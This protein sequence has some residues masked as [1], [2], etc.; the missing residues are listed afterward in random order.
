MNCRIKRWDGEYRWHTVR[1]VPT[2]PGPQGSNEWHATA[3]DVHELRLAEQRLNETQALAKIGSW[4]FDPIRMTR[5]WTDAVYSMFEMDQSEEPF[6]FEGFLKLVHPHDRERIS[7]EMPA[8]MAT[9]GEFVLE[10][11]VVLPSG[12]EKVIRTVARTEVEEGRVTRILGTGQDVTEERTADADRLRLAAVVE[13]SSDLVATCDADGKTLFMNRALRT[14]VGL[15]MDDCIRGLPVSTFLT[16][17]LFQKLLKDWIP[18]SIMHGSWS[19]EAEYESNGRRLATSLM[20]IAHANADGRSMYFSLVARDI[21]SIKKSERALEHTNGLLQEAARHFERLFHGLPIACFSYGVD[22]LVREWNPAAE[23]MFG[24]GASDAYEQPI[25]DV[26]RGSCRRKSFRTLLNPVFQGEDMEGVELNIVRKDGSTCIAV[27][28]TMPVRDRSGVVIAALSAFVDV[29]EQRRATKKLKANEQ[30]LQSIAAS[31]HEG[32]IVEDA[33]GAIILTNSSAER[34]LGVSSTKLLALRSTDQLWKA[35]GEDGT[36]LSPEE[37]PSRIARLS[38]KPTFGRKMGIK[39][40]ANGLVW[41]N[42]NAIPI[43]SKAEDDGLVV[44]SFSD[45]SAEVENLSTIREYSERLEEANQ[46]LERLATTDGLTG[47]R[48]HRTFQEYLEREF[49]SSVRYERPLSIALLDVDRFKLINDDF[50]H[51]VGDE[52]LKQIAR[53]LETAARDADFVARYGGEEFVVVMPETGRDAALVAAERFRAIIEA[54]EW[55]GRPVTASFGV[56]TLTPL[57]RHRAALI[58]Q[59]DQALYAAKRAGRNRSVHYDSLPVVD[60]TQAA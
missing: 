39:K 9:E 30:R 53:I 10:Y 23:R 55:K 26:V 15:G 54:A 37:V 19:G 18:N 1:V 14:F 50:G 45:I 44:T 31:M 24:I 52:T 49:A 36:S 58:E 34:I 3:I 7:R 6:D 29:S 47:L 4:E 33:R 11:R 21:S 32:L 25:W 43:R 28:S 40:G 13:S 22:G 51:Q 60:S 12:T 16:E 56:A 38:S 20:L 8:A 42:V 2:A 5:A 57:V 48:N 27:V 46:T 35:V 41:L 17:S 59:S